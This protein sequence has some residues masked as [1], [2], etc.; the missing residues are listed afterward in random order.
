[1]TKSRRLHLISSAKS[2]KFDLPRLSPGVDTTEF[3]LIMNDGNFDCAVVIIKTSL[4]PVF[5]INN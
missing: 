4:S 2:I 5:V 1:M 3:C